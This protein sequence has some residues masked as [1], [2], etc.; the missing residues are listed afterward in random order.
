MVWVWDQFWPEWKDAPESEMSIKPES[1]MVIKLTTS[2]S[3]VTLLERISCLAG[4]DNS[5]TTIGQA[6]ALFKAAKESEIRGEGQLAIVREG[7]V[8]KTFDLS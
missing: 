1:E 6:L 3:F 7:K 4:H 5:A 2:R 8:V